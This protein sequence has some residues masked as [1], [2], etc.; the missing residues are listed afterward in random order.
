MN[1]LEAKAD[2]RLFGSH[3]RP[4]ESWAAWD[5]CLAAIFGLEL[6]GGDLGRE[7]FERH[8]GRAVA[9]TSPARE[10]WLIVG[11]RGGK[12][13]VAALVAVYLA[14]FRDYA[15]V[16]APGE[17][18]TV[19][20]IAADRRQARTLLRYVR[21][22]LAVPMLA[23]MVE[24]EVAEGVDLT[25]GV[26]I[27]VHTASFRAVRGYTLVAAICDEVAFWRVDEDA[28]EPDR[29]ILNALRPGMA[30]CPGALLLAIS[31]PYA[32]RGELWRAYERHFGKDGDVLVWQAPTRAMHPAV[33]Q[34]LI[35]AAAVEDE[36]SA[37]AEYGAQFRRDV[38]S[39]VSREAVEAAVIGDRAEL[40]PDRHR[41]EYLGFV[42]AAG[43]SGQDSMTLALAHAEGER[44]VLDVLRE[45]RP[46]FSPDA[47]CADFAAVLREYAV[48]RVRG[49]RYAGSWPASR[50]AAHGIRYEPSERTKSEIYAAFLPL[51]NSGRVE[52]LDDPRLK[53]QLLG[54]ERRTARGGRDSIDHA[55]R[56][57]DDLANAA[58]GALVMLGSAPKPAH[59][60]D[61]RWG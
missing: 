43:G 34:E 26:T 58:A 31:S 21:G 25:N 38:E 33:P 4:V 7:V 42:D 30:T 39:F 36:S 1:I 37:L 15:G 17:R 22:L 40:P 18:G 5:V 61:V 24:R 60:V 8:T 56:S 59:A 23:A 54:L 45:V 16:L 9:P 44:V 52:L 35:D 13:R 29:E 6:P 48:A 53:R 51:L 3:F 19:M 10:A 2:A 47:V 32:R 28:A 55:P 14:C 50:L 12:S 46:P 41:H 20:L 11:R 49:D 57:H 27:E